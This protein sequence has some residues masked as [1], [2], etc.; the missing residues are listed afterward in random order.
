MSNGIRTRIRLIPL[1]LGMAALAVLWSCDGENLFSPG[2]TGSFNDGQDSG[3]PPVVEIQQPREPAARPIGDSVL[4]TAQASDDVG[5]DSILFGGVAFRG[6]V[7]LGTDT[8]VT[9]YFSKMV[10]FDQTRLSAFVSPSSL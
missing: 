8:I 4:I 1:S 2:S 7:D 9:R 3:I 10:R 6:D 5:L